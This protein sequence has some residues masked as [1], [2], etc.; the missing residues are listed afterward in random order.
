VDDLSPSALR[1]TSFVQV[2]IVYKPLLFI[3]QVDIFNLQRVFHS[4]YFHES[5]KTKEL[6][7]YRVR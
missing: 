7:F 1:D 4:K 2:L 5:E 6:N 3:F